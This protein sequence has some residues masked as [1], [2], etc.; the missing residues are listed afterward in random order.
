[1][2]SQGLQGSPRPCTSLWFVGTSDVH[3]EDMPGRQSQVG[4]LFQGSEGEGMQGSHR[5]VCCTGNYQ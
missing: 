2:A 5:T 4:T 3:K 1:M